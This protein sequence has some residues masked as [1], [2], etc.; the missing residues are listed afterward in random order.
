MLN[1][2]FVTSSSDAQGL[3]RGE[4]YRVLAQLR[5]YMGPLVYT[6]HVLVAA[7]GRVLFVGNLPLVAS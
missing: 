6:T 5:R 2:K 7:D 4:R 3:S 1:G